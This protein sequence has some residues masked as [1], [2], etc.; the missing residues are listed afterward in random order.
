MSPAVSVD[1]SAHR[2]E[3]SAGERRVADGKWHDVAFSY[4]SETGR[5][6]FY[7]DGQ[8]ESRTGNLVRKARLKKPMLRIG[9]TSRNF[10]GKSGFRGRMSEVRFYN[11]V[12]RDADHHPRRLTELHVPAVRDG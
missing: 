5:I 2:L 4:A 7:I 6:R 3:R 9:Y 10:P 1:R 8:P 11:A 12:L